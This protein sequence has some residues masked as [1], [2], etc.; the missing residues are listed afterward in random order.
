M[1]YLNSPYVSSI[2]SV[3]SSIPSVSSS[4]GCS[5]Y[6]ESAPGSA[7]SL[8]HSYAPSEYHV[9]PRRPLIDKIVEEFD[10]QSESPSNSGRNT[11]IDVGV[12][13]NTGL[14]SEFGYASAVLAPYRIFS[15][16]FPAVVQQVF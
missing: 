2:P 12:E 15:I 9:G 11:P 13:D 10:T 16:L 1:M 14:S 4:S 8:D 5:S 7:A 3:N 6:S